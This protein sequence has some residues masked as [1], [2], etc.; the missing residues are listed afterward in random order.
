MSD[1][2]DDVTRE[3]ADDDAGIHSILDQF[4][5]L[6]RALVG[7]TTVADALQ[8]IV[9]T[10]GLVVAGADLVSV[11]VRAPDG[12]FY[13]PARTAPVASELDQV[14][15]RAGD[16]PCLDAAS[17]DGPGYVA[18]DDLSTET[19]WP[20]FSA[21]ASGHGYGAIISTELVP[22]AKPMALS[23]ALNIYSREPH[24]LS[25][26]DRHTALLF[27]T[28]GALALAHAHA[29]ELADLQRAQLRQAIDTRDV[30][31]QAKGILMNRQGITADE[32]FELLRRTS[33]DLNMKLVDVARAL[34]AR[35]AAD[36]T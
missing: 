22:A 21:A 10:A 7:A 5:S 2:N 3:S 1:V 36:E 31:G 34:A 35:A 13:T 4:E 33:Q 28:H 12:T 32:A 30:I 16:G 9:D 27:A 14:Q 26:T 25:R 18:S 19:R 23:G 11:T 15:Y 24:G 8:H 6:T 17:P 20:E 29:S